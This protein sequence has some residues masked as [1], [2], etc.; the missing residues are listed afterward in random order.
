[1]SKSRRGEC[2]VRTR[3]L[4]LSRRTSAS[5]RIAVLCIERA[6]F[7]SD[8]RHPA[9]ATGPRGGSARS[10]LAIIHRPVRQIVGRHGNNLVPSL[11]EAGGGPDGASVCLRDVMLFTA[12]ASSPSFPVRPTWKPKLSEGANSKKIHAAPFEI[13]F[14]V[15][16]RAFPRRRGHPGGLSKMSEGGLY[17]TD[18]TL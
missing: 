17:R 2:G 6:V 16:K 11:R 10:R 5:E 13:A 8:S 4:G 3:A 14:M 15:P 7:R 9:D 12:T 18:G 1:M